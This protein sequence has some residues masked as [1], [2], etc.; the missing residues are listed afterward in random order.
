MNQSYILTSDGIKLIPASDIPIRMNFQ[1]LDAREPGRLVSD[2]SLPFEFVRN[3][4][5]DEFFDYAYLPA[6][7][8]IPGVAT[9]I[10]VTINN[11]TGVILIG[12]LVLEEWPSRENGD[13]YVCKFRTSVKTLSDSIGD[14]L[15]S[16][17]DWSALDHPYQMAT[18]Q[19][20][21]TDTS[22]NSYFYP[23]VD[24]GFDAEGRPDV[25]DDSILV[26]SGVI[27]QEDYTG[28]Y[29]TSFGDND[30]NEYRNLYGNSRRTDAYGNRIRNRISIIGPS[31]YFGQVAFGNLQQGYITH[32][33]TPL[34]IDQLCSPAVSSRAVFDR[35]FELS[36][37]TYEAD[38]L[39]MVADLYVQPK[40]QSGLGLLP[41]PDG[42]LNPDNGF[43]LSAANSLSVDLNLRSS[44]NRNNTSLDRV[45]YLFGR[46]SAIA[47]IFPL[48]AAP[49]Y[50]SDG[51]FTAPTNGLYEFQ[52]TGDME[53]VDRFNGNTEFTRV[54]AVVRKNG[55]NS[56]SN[57]S[58]YIDGDIIAQH[59]F[60]EI[61]N[62][63]TSGLDFSWDLV[64]SVTLFVGDV[65]T[66][67][68][69]NHRNRGGND[70]RA[71]I[72]DVEFNTLFTPI[73]WENQT[74]NI[75]E[76]FGDTRAVDIFDGFR[77]QMN[78][79]P[80][81]S[82]TQRN[83][84]NVQQYYDWILSGKRVELGNKLEN[85]TY[86]SLIPD[87]QA[88]VTFASADSDDI[89]S[90]STAGDLTYGS[91]ERF[92]DSELAEGDEI[93]G[94]FFA[95]TIVATP[96]LVGDP[97]FTVEPDQNNGI[98]HIYDEDGGS[99]EA[100]IRLGFKRAVGLDTFYYASDNDLS[101]GHRGNVLTLS[102][103]RQGDNQDSNFS[104]E[105]NFSN[106]DAEG[107][108]D[109]FWKDYM[110]FL[111][112]P[113]GVKMNADIYLTPEEASD[114]RLNDTY[115]Y[116][117]RD[118]LLQSIDGANMSE[119]GLAS[120]EF[121]SYNNNFK[122]RFTNARNR[123]MDDPGDI[124][125]TTVGVK[126]TSRLE[127]TSGGVTTSVEEP[128]ALR[129]SSFLLSDQGT[130]AQTV[131]G[132]PQPAETFTDTIVIQAASAYDVSASN[133]TSN[134]ATLTGVTLSAF[135]D[136]MDG[137]VEVDVTRTVQSVHT[138]Q[139]L[140]ITGAVARRVAGNFDYDIDFDLPTGVETGVTISFESADLRGQTGAIGFA[141]VQIDPPAGRAFDTATGFTH[142]DLP[143]GVTL[144]GF[145]SIG[146]SVR[147]RFRVE[148]QESNR[149]ETIIITPIASVIL[150]S[151]VDT[152]LV[153]LDIQEQ[154]GGIANTT[155]N[156]TQIRFMA[157]VGVAAY[158]SIIASAD[159][160]YTLDSVNFS[161]TE[162]ISGL[163]A[164]NAVGSGESVIIPLEYTPSASG[165]TGTITV[166]GSAQLIGADLY[167]YTT[168]ITAS[169]DGAANLTIMERTETFMLN[170]GMS[171]VYATYLVASPGYNLLVSD[172]QLPPGS[173]WSLAQAGNDTL[174]LTR[175]ISIDGENPANVTDTLALTVA[176]LD[177]EPYGLDF[178]FNS[179]SITFG[180]VM[181]STR[182]IG[183]DRADTTYSFTIEVDSDETH[184]W[185]AA[186]L[187]IF[188]IGD[189]VNTD[190]NVTGTPAGF[191][192]I[193]TDTAANISTEG[194]ATITINGNFPS[195]TSGILGGHF[196]IPIN[197]TGTPQDI[198][199]FTLTFLINSQELTFA[200]S[201][202]ITHALG[203]EEVDTTFSF[204]FNVDPNTDFVYQ[205]T[206][207]PT[208]TVGTI[209]NTD[210]GD[211][212][213]HTINTAVAVSG[214]LAR[215]TI[216]GDYPSGDSIANLT[217][218]INV[219]GEPDARPS[220]T[221]TVGSLG[222]IKSGES[223]TVNLTSNGAWEVTPS[224]LRAIDEVGY[225][226]A[227]RSGF[228]NRAIVVTPTLVIGTNGQIVNADG[229]NGNNGFSDTFSIGFRSQ[230]ATTNL[231]TASGT[232][233]IRGVS[234]NESGNDIVVQSNQVTS[235]NVNIGGQAGPDAGVLYIT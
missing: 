93:V 75:G 157:I 10:D 223:R 201:D 34:R 216:S 53:N 118:W 91:L 31:S 166:N 37:S 187:P 96:R 119:G 225:T 170:A 137:D 49:A 98:P 163:T 57:Q 149:S 81:R 135:R 233:T 139:I 181:D 76:Q 129:S 230:G 30:Y 122:T 69:E 83:H 32:P 144:V 235:I 106:S 185:S 23:I 8:T 99:I 198:G 5:N 184:S 125:T 121:I 4:E 88:V 56:S 193:T 210:T 161:V 6:R 51:V 142:S 117:G 116:E 192:F 110:D 109:L 151:G 2:E 221:I 92:N 67:S 104:S 43:R 188:T 227:P 19:S 205:A 228:G 1:T 9:S 206:T 54:V 72:V 82:R 13:R 97:T 33:A 186:N 215:I 218:P 55:T 213:T 15:L 177:P 190:N 90:Q 26:A 191:T 111:Q 226:V 41:P 180:G 204:G 220:T 74:V 105:Y 229:S 183:Y 219:V 17:A 196:V 208:P 207:L 73:D 222:T 203:Y 202:M 134:A 52:F 68:L 189:I 158:P 103:A 58:D 212:V 29:T 182:F 3:E 138:Y 42:F 79:I 47:R 112:D 145:I 153:V 133:Y 127:T 86:S 27:T 167:S 11:D 171:Q 132:T 102:N 155:L 147:G 173:D 195:D 59:N 140:E 70:I 85:V 25:P 123:F 39:D 146:T 63:D 174:I 21:S 60:P 64:F 194:V 217:I 45:A 16:D 224:G 62:D 71:D 175:T 28:T 77:T 89:L 136:R 14:M 61:T 95:P 162:S 124:R 199:P 114:M 94:D 101:I 234:R 214:E 178:R 152:V 50:L 232:C 148:Y 154:A 84:Y 20:T 12:S 35:V 115:H 100:G 141:D 107:F 130:F 80:E 87:Q 209:T 108:Y 120:V 22:P 179:Q 128:G 65:I 197:V 231:T 78:L 126:I 38:F 176:E 211:T 46:D 7:Q 164:F 40:L 48:G 200:G 44:G 18:W 143:D 156:R 24:Y 169:G 172:V 150:P 160:T 36:G 165:N 66:C 131:E 168:S 159:D 113:E